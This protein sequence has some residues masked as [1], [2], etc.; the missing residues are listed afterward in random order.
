MSVT[1]NLNNDQ[2]SVHFTDHEKY[3]VLH[4]Y[5]YDGSIE[6]MDNNKNKVRLSFDQTDENGIVLKDGNS[7]EMELEINLWKDV[8]DRKAVY[9]ELINDFID[10]L[11]ETKK[12]WFINQHDTAYKKLLS[13]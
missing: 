8:A 2:S 5:F 9:V 6:E 11:D 1:M 3:F 13:N 7:F 12:Q 10:Q 4:S